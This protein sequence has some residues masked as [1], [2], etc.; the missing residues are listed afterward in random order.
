MDHLPSREKER[1]RKRMRSPEAY[2]RLR[3]KVKGPEDLKEEMDK[4][5]KLAE[6]SFALEIEPDMH[7]RLKGEV[8]KD[9]REKGAENILDM[10]KNIPEK[11]KAALAEGKFRLAVT[12]HPVTHQDVLTILPEGTVQEKIPV[13]TSMSESYANQALTKK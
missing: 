3:E 1:I 8:L 6:L 7:D 5:E 12:S 11:T 10:P 2:E 9:I 13:K 4:A